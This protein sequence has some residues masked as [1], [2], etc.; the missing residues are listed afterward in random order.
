MH[1]YLGRDG[2]PPVR[3]GF[4]LASTATG[5]AAAQG[6]LAGLLRRRES[7]AGQR[8][9]VSML[10]SAL[11]INQWSTVAE[12]GPDAPV[13]R[14]LQGQDWRRDHGFAS[15]DG[16]CLIGFRQEGMWRRFVVAIGRVDLLGDP[17]FENAVKTHA[18]LFAY[19]VEGTLHAWSIDSLARLVRDE[20][21]GTL[22]PVLDLERLIA[23]EQ[24][25]NL[26]IVD[27]SDGLRV[28]LPMDTDAGI[29]AAGV[30]RG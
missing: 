17:V 23:H 9:D 22:V 14:Q 18:P 6:I 16:P 13:G 30:R 12:S 21:G 26:G 7:G 25:R 19:R 1:R 24:V 27:R 3:L 4:D 15:R 5:L 10:A 28:A 8:V 20:L 2:E 29:L 11:A